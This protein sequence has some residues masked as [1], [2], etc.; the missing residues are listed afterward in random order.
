M[1]K[2]IIVNLN[3]NAYQLEE[4]GYEALRAY[5]DSA[6]RRLEGNP[7]RD[8]IIADIEQAIADKFRALMGASKTVV[9]T[10]EVEGVIAEMGPV[11][12]T[13]DTP[14]AGPKGAAEAP[15]AAPGAG[16]APGP[17]KRLYRI[18]DGAM[19]AGVCNGI[20]AYLNIDVT[21]VRIVFV[22]LTLAYG[23]GALFYVIMV[24]LIPSAVTSTE[25]AAAHGAPFTA[26]EFIRRAREGYYEGMRSFGD[27][28][29]RREWKRRFKQEMRGWRQDF[30]RE[31]HETAYQCAN[32]WRRHWDQRPFPAVGWMIGVP[33]LRLLSTLVSLLCVFSLVSLLATGA[34]FGILLPASIPVWAG[35]VIL[36][37]AF[38]VVAL[39]LRVM[40]HAMYYGIGY[41]PVCAGWLHF[42]NAVAALG[43]LAVVVWFAHSHSVQVHEA[44]R[45]LPHEIH[46]GV[47]AIRD[48]WEK[49]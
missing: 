23:A 6:A 28:R 36:L 38:Q 14:A 42:W 43:F 21:I 49:P 31:M 27:R 40:R 7:D 47:D 33:V 13:S 46:R 30:Q 10:R 35:L 37:I 44:V 12:D 22:A 2:V 1:N 24:F 11:E 16:E 3:G 39:P 29:A 41:N 15:K 18:N 45:G 4:N 8:E 25:K 9:A 5:L 34:V 17:A 32:N 19:L 20:A 26:Q 48:W